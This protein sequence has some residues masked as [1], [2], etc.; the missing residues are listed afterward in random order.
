MLLSCAW[1]ICL[2]WLHIKTDDSKTL[3]YTNEF[4]FAIVE[5][6]A[7]LSAILGE[8]FN[9]SVKY[10]WGIREVGWYIA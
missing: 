6:F 5:Y 4:I 2:H 1:I 7:M 9:I 8:S 10:Y 3:N